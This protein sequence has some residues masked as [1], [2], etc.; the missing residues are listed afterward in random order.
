MA[1]AVALRER[2]PDT[3]GQGLLAVSRFFRPSDGWLA[4][5]LLAL[6]L[7]VVVWSVDDADWAPTPAR[8]ILNPNLPKRYHGD[9]S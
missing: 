7:I 4:V 3:L 5:G 9:S 1:E 2:M 6:N 8:T